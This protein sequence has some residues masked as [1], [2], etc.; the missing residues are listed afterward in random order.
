MDQEIADGHGETGWVDVGVDVG[1]DDRSIDRTGTGT[2]VSGSIPGTHR[3]RYGPADDTDSDRSTRH[4]REL[5]TDVSLEPVYADERLYAVSDGSLVALEA[6]G[7][8]RAWTFSTSEE[9]ASSAVVYGGLIY[10]R[11]EGTLHAIRSEHGDGCWS[12][13]TTASIRGPPVANDELVVTTARSGAVS[14]VTAEYGRA[15]RSFRPPHRPSSATLA[16]GDLYVTS[17]EGGIAAYDATAGTER[18]RFAPNCAMFAPPVVD[19]EAVYVSTVDDGGVCALDR[20]TGG[21]RWSQRVGSSVWTRPLVSA[22]TVF[23]GGDDGTL[24]AIRPADGVELWTTVVPERLTSEP[25]LV[26]DTLYVGCTDGMYAMHPETGVIRRRFELCGDVAVVPG[27]DS[28]FVRDQRGSLF[29]A[30]V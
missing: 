10:W 20:E 11:T 6:D 25:V 13:P 30:S 24:V 1:S 7:S 5:Y 12:T 15:V 3:E 23:V 8:G 14:V 16:D 26:G 27:S 29:V 9:P 17:L 21:P 22:D 19:A 28:V 2:V 4:L 18:W